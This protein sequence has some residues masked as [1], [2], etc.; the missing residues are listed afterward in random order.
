MVNKMDEIIFNIL[1]LPSTSEFFFKDQILQTQFFTDGKKYKI[2]QRL[3]KKYI[4]LMKLKLSRARSPSSISN[5]ELEIKQSEEAKDILNQMQREVIEVRN[6]LAHCHP[7]VDKKNT[8]ISKT[9]ETEYD[10]NKCKTI[11]K[12]YLKHAKNLDK[13]KEILN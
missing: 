13:I 2:I 7:S 1:K 9:G 8:L 12:N 6:E 11:R 5:L 10:D 3:L 4:S